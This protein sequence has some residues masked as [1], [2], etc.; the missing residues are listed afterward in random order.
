[1]I[2]MMRTANG[3]P[4]AAASALWKPTSFS[5]HASLLT[6]STR[7]ASSRAFRAANCDLLPALAALLAHQPSSVRLISKNSPTFSSSIPISSPTFFSGILEPRH[8]ETA[9]AMPH[10]DQSG[11]FRAIDRLANGLPTS[12]EYRGELPLGRQPTLDPEAAGTDE[13]DNLLEHLVGFARALDRRERSQRRSPHSQAFRPRHCRLPLVQP[14]TGRARA[15]AEID[16]ANLLVVLEVR[17]LALQGDAPGLQ[18][19]GIVGD[20]KRQR[21]RLLGQQQ[22]QAF[23]M[24]ALQ[25]VVER[26]DHCGR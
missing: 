26:L 17:R 6:S 22:G 21:N 13:A 10:L 11:Q 14:G 23:L 12:V 2:S 18:H 1:M 7:I 25:H 24:Q 8:D 16:F 19:V 20:A 5:S 4:V 3:L 15:N 9:G